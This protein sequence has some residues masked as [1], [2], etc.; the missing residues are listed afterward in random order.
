MQIQ[1]KQRH[2]E[3]VKQRDADWLRDRLDLW[4]PRVARDEA[5]CVAAHNARLATAAEQRKQHESKLAEAAA[6]RQRNKEDGERVRR[7]DSEYNAKSAEIAVQKLEEQ[8][9]NMAVLD[10][11]K[12]QHKMDM[13]QAARTEREQDAKIQQWFEQK[14]QLEN[15]RKAAEQAALG[16][17]ASCA[18]AARPSY[19]HG[20]HTTSNHYHSFFQRPAPDPPEDWRK[21][22]RGARV[23]AQQEE[24]MGRYA[25]ETE[26][27]GGAEE[28]VGS[29]AEETRRC[30]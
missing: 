25:H 28:R 13:E 22:I 5:A 8:K 11:M 24:R 14:E 15:T 19:W 10:Q 21:T 23:G 18:S 26:A 17:A 30:R 12:E 1:Y 9:Q 29:R 4:A 7:I 6:E 2:A 20:D 3:A 27:E 16:Y